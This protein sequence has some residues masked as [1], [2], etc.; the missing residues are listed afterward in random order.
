[1]RLDFPGRG[2]VPPAQ[3]GDNLQ[4]GLFN[5]ASEFEDFVLQAVQLLFE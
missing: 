1:V 3:R 2:H 5:R 4:H